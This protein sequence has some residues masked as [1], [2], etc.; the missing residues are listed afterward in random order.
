VATDIGQ[1]RQ[2][3]SG[4]I[5]PAFAIEDLSINVIDGYVGPG[6]A[7]ATPAIFELIKRVAEVEGL[8][9]DPVYTAKGFLGMLDQIKQGRFDDS[10]DIVFVHTGGIFGLFAQRE[11]LQF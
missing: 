11:Q 6:Y 8:V 2:W 5:D 9:L 4:L 7:K 3:Y 1:W 10:D